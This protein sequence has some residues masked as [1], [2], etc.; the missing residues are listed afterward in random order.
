MSEYSEYQDA[1]RE[2]GH[3]KAGPGGE[4]GNGNISGCMVVA[5]VP[6]AVAMAAVLLLMKGRP[7]R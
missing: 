6:A 3:K 4:N 5:P 7:R 1:A 2:K